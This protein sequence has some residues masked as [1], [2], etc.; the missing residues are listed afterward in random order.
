M[1]SAAYSAEGPDFLENLLLAEKV[2][3][4]AKIQGPI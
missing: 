4:F 1:F 3:R 2:R